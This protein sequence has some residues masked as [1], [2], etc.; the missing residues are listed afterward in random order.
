MRKVRKDLQVIFQDPFASLNPRQTVGSILEEAIA[1]Q[2]VCPK[3]ERMAKVIES[4]GKL[5]LHLMQ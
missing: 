5:V 2:N 3:G 1:I 4:S